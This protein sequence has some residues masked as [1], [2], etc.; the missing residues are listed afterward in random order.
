ML[1]EREQ[2]AAFRLELGRVGFPLRTTDRTEEN[3][4]GR[5]AGFDCVFRERVSTVVE[6]GAADEFFDEI[7]GESV[8]DGDTIEH[9]AGF[10]HDF[11]TDPVAGENCNLIDFANGPRP[12]TGSLKPQAES[13]PQRNP[14]STTWDP[15]GH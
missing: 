14:Q 8:L 2:S 11:G 15:A 3:G 10:A 6:S 13:G 1:A 5:L 4:I 9:L 12:K 7:K